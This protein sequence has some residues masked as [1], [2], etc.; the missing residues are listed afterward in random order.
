MTT[1][2]TAVVD[3]LG[4]ATALAYDNEIENTF[5][6]AAANVNDNAYDN[7]YDNER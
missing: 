2:S 3:A 5:S 6:S 1:F 7:A 4:Y